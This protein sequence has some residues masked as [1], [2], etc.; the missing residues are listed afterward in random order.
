MTTESWLN[1]FSLEKLFNLE[2]SNSDHSPIFLVPQKVEVRKMRC[3]FKF[4]N[5]WLLEPLC[6]KLVN[7]GWRTSEEHDIQS[8][9]KALKR[10]CN[11]DDEHSLAEYE[12]TRRKLNLTLDQREIFWRL[13]NA[14]GIWQEWDAGLEGLIINYYKELFSKSQIEWEE[15]LEYVVHGTREMG[16]IFPTRGIHQGDPLSPYLFILCA[17]GLTAL[18]RKYEAQKFIH[19][20]KMCRRAPIITHM[21]FADDSSIYCK[22]NTEEA[23]NMLNLLAVFRSSNTASVR[24]E[25]ICEVLYIQEAKERS[26]YLG[27]P[28]ILGHNKS[29]VLGY[30]K[31]RVEQSVHNWDGR[32]IS[33]SGKEALIKTVAQTFPS[34]NMSV[35][36][37]PWGVIKDIERVLTKFWWRSSSQ[38][39]TGWRF[40][41]NPGRFMCRLFKAKYFPDG[42][43]LSAPV[44]NNPSF[45]W[46]SVCEAK[47]LVKA[48]ARWMVGTDSLELNANMVSSLMFTDRRAWDEDLIKDMFNVRDQQCILKT[49]LRSSV[50]DDRI[51]W[52]KENSGQYSIWR[53]KAPP[54]VLNLIW[55]AMS[56]CLPTMSMLTVKNVLVIEICPIYN[57]DPD[58]IMHILVTC[59]LAYQCWQILILDVHQGVEGDFNGWLGETLKHISMDRSA[60]LVTEAQGRSVEALVQ[61]IHAGDGATSWVKQQIGTIKVTGDAALFEEHASFGTGL[62]ARDHR[63]DLV[64]AKT[65]YHG[66]KILLEIMEAIAIKEALSWI[67]MKGW[68]QVELEAD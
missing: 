19:G 53:I 33:R 22:E 66:E 34:Y 7:E 40:L 65:S 32:F 62:V 13:R 17:E 64:L 46:R 38:Q 60:I 58:S 55:R 28:N 24:R 26:A 63:G 14:E 4:E 67:K 54:K 43:F 2:G 20:I 9:V 44:G 56:F 21:L 36:L 12:N 10:L 49:P 35:F 31:D 1:M 11:K 68:A 25:E 5:A 50:V 23:A 29:A 42:N 18:I 8:K 37:L 30:L 61:E 6:H 47:S 45:L 3:R 51:Y 27:L 57:G 59:P 39:N 16:P 41:I 48:G 52:S 15:V